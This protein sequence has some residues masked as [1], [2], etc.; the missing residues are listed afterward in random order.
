MMKTIILSFV[1]LLVG[2]AATNVEMLNGY[3]TH[4]AAQVLLNE[5]L[6][7]PGLFVLML[8]VIAGNHF[9]AGYTDEFL[10]FQLSLLSLILAVL[11]LVF[12]TRLLVLGL[13]LLIASAYWSKKNIQQYF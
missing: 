12:F 7:I 9:I 11:G 10:P 8:M 4:P 2:L 1:T 3:V 5:Y 6:L 13:L